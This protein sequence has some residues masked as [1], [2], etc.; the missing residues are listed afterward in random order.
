MGISRIHSLPDAIN[1]VG[2]SRGFSDKS[3]SYAEKNIEFF[4]LMCPCIPVKSGFSRENA[5]FS[6]EYAVLL[7]VVDWLTAI[8]GLRMIQ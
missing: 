7:I 2:K 8:K 1:P 5:K 3:Q 4:T 6:S